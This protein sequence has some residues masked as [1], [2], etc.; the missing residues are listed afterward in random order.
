MALES[1]AQ[2]GSCWPI[3]AYSVPRPRSTWA[4]AMRCSGASMGLPPTQMRWCCSECRTARSPEGAV[5]TSLHPRR[6]GCGGTHH[7]VRGGGKQGRD[8]FVLVRPGCQPKGDGW[9]GHSLHAV[10]SQGGGHTA[11]R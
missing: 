4:S 3:V 10:R 2:D 11:C 1:A 8:R 9:L 5:C 6:E 7:V